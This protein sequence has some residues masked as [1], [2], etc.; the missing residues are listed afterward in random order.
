LSTNVKQVRLG[1]DVAV[2]CGLLINELVSNCLKHAF[3]GRQQGH[4][5]IELQTITED[6]I[7]LMIADDGL[8]LPEGIE[9]ERAETFGLQVVAALVDQIRG[10]M[11]ISR[12]RGT[13]FR[14]LFPRSNNG[15]AAG[16]T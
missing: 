12:Q 15:V 14:I 9:P 16:L 6:D 3:V 4:I 5:Y 1:I 2:P 13:E 7:L 8:G 11:D 10:R